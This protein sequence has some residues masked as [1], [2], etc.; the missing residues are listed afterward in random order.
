VRWVVPMLEV[1]GLLNDNSAYNV[2][3]GVHTLLLLYP[4]GYVPLYIDMHNIL[5]VR[6]ESRH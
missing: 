6:C 4:A 2:E 5:T 1:G 3:N